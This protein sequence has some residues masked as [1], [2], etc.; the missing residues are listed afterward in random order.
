[1]EILDFEGFPHYKMSSS[2][3]IQNLG[4]IKST[5]GFTIVRLGSGKTPPSSNSTSVSSTVTSATNS[6]SSSPKDSKA[7]TPKTSKPSS[8]KNSPILTPM[9]FSNATFKGSIPGAGKVCILGSDCYPSTYIPSMFVC[10]D[11]KE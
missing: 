11:C 4:N 7:S 5:K 2:P 1:M 9:N 6:A 3:E 10:R 8:P